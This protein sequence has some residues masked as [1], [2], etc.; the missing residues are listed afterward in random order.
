MTNSL[1]S[2][3]KQARIA[4]IFYLLH[5]ATSIYGMIY[6]SSK[7]N[8]NGNAAATVNNIIANEFI[9]RS[10]IVNR[11]IS[12]I[13]WMLLSITLYGLLKQVNGFY[14]KLMFAWMTLSIPVGF[15]AEGFNICGLMIAKGELMQSIDIL[16]RQDYAVLFLNIYNN[17]ISISEMFWGLWLLPFGFLIYKS[18]F[19]PRILGV[20][21]LLGG[22]GYITGCITFLLFPIY[23][24]S[25]DPYTMIFGSAGEI[26]IMLWLLIKGVKNNIRAFDKE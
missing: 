24:S 15:I 16:Q 10:G 25:V 22:T 7:I 18:R 26:T 12:S 6:V 20:L 11:I 4:G 1:G 19:I 2:L 5:V 13:P 3:K 17:I 9:F 8:M 21:L 14:A 23:K